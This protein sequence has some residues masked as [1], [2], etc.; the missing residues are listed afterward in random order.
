MQTY[1]A[2]HLAHLVFG[3]PQAHAGI[4]VIPLLFEGN[5][6]PDY[7]SMSEAMEQHALLVTEVDEAGSVPDLKVTSKSDHPILLLDG[8]ELA[9]AKQ[10]RVLNTTILLK[11]RADILIPVSCTESGRWGYTTD[12]FAESGHVM[13]RTARARKSRSVSSSLRDRRV[14]HSDQGEVWESVDELQE[15]SGTSSPTSAM[16]DVYV[17][18]AN[19]IADCLTAFSMVPDQKGLLVIVNGDVSGFDFVSKPAAYTRLH[20]KLLKSYVVEALF[21]K[22]K[23]SESSNPLD[24]AKAFLYDVAKAEETCFD[25]LGYGNDYRYKGNSTVGSC[26]A[27]EEKVVHAA[28][29][30]LDEG[31]DIDGMS[32][33]SHRRRYRSST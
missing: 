5:G 20:P 18:R 9:G 31:K 26:L 29:F 17:Q 11:E 33:M 16:S 25:S 24:L 23:P 10:N 19:E 4:V 8:E 14:F 21:R 12:F 27:Y 1:I 22:E 30:R 28:F 6:V 3:E 15:I 7:L 32:S 2:D 13:S